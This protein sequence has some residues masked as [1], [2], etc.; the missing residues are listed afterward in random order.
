MPVLSS[1]VGNG[2]K[3]GF[4]EF[5]VTFDPSLS[6]GGGSSGI[7]NFTGTYSYLIAPDDGAGNP[8]VAP[9]DSFIVSPVTQPIIGP[10]AASLPAG[11]LRIPIS[12]TG[13]TGTSDDITTSALT[14]GGAVNQLITGI[15]VNLS[16][17]HQNGSDLVITLTAPDGQT[18]TVPTNFGPGPVTLNNA[19]FVVVGLG[20]GP[21]DGT[22]TLTIDDTASN[23]TG[24]LTGWSVTIASVLPTLG[25]QTGAPDDQNAD[26]IAR[27]EPDDAARRLHR[28]DPGR[29]LR[30]AHAPGRRRRS[31]SPP[32][33]ASSARRSTRTP[34]P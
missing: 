27:R 33:R 1:G 3:F 14:I 2:N 28:P 24:T 13:G 32:P 31:R 20:G 6:P 22:Y 10:V 26:G 11:G 25:L 4:T 12:G 21:V 9:V 16:L 29:R 8:I 15:T 30:R 19:P 18:A 23:N 7:G 17:T 34:C 5:T